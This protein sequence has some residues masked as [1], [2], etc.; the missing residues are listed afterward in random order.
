MTSYADTTEATPGRARIRLASLGQERVEVR[1]TLR[2]LPQGGTVALR[3]A[4]G[5]WTTWR[6]DGEWLVREEE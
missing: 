2:G 4:D 1:G 6:R 5:K 3:W